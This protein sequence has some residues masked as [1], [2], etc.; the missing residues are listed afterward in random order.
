MFALKRTRILIWLFVWVVAAAFVD[1]GVVVFKNGGVLV[2]TQQTV[3]GGEIS[4]TT[5][6]G[7]ATFLLDDVSWYSKDGSVSSLYTGAQATQ[8]EGKQEVA[9]ILAKEAVLKEPANTADARPHETE[10]RPAAPQ[11]PLPGKRKMHLSV[12]RVS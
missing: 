12:T 9:L 3:T 4:I 8:C 10:S 1:A 5:P 11:Q 6:G 7:N 2:T